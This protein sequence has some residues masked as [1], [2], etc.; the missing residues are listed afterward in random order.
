MAGDPLVAT[1]LLYERDV[2]DGHVRLGQRVQHERLGTRQLDH[3]GR[4]VRGLDGL[5][6]AELSGLHVVG[7]ARAAG[8]RRLSEAATA[9]AS[10]GRPL[11]KVTPSRILKVRVVPSE[12]ISH[13]SA[14]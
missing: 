2:D 3:E 8:E 12:E 9:P 1:H 13:D 14:R 6:V 4:G 7:A 11:G 5:R 10:T